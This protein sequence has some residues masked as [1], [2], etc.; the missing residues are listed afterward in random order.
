MAPETPAVP[1][2]A[3]V[4]RLAREAA[5][6][7]A[8]AAAE[9]TRRHDAKGVSAAYWRDVERGYGG[10]RGQRVPTR[11]SARALAAMAR[12][13]G[14]VPPQLAVAGREDAARVLEEIHRREQGA[15][16]PPEPGPPAESGADAEVNAEVLSLLFRRKARNHEAEVRAE[17]RAAKAAYRHLLLEQVP[18]GGTEP[19][20]T[21][22]PGAAIP[23]FD[24]MERII[25]D[26]GVTFTEDERAERIARNRA[27]AEAD[28]PAPRAR[29]A[30]LRK[31]DALT[32]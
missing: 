1:P 2:E 10:R 31:P 29:R 18:E 3:E 13:V 19:G 5:D 25:W 11:A 21:D 7:T 24:A 4:I 28:R 22:L 6:M 27:A 14:V 16:A 15:A 9:T 8:Q 30:G 17:I 32:A 20:P 12:V 23:A 26:L